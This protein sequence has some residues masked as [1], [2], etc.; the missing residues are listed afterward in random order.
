MKQRLIAHAAALALAT[1]LIAAPQ[2]QAT[3]AGPEADE[4]KIVPI[5][6]IAD[7]DEQSDDP[8]EPVTYENPRPPAGVPTGPPVIEIAWGR[9]A[10]PQHAAPAA[11][12]GFSFDPGIIAAIAIGVLAAVIGGIVIL[13]KP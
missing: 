7:L 13:L 11:I 12:A 8:N 6:D 2:S 4:E 10:A 3:T 5:I 9:P 1:T